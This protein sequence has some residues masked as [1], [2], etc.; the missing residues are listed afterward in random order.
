MT[1]ARYDEGPVSRFLVDD[2]LEDAPVAVMP[3]LSFARAL[4]TSFANALQTAHALTTTAVGAVEPRFSS[5]RPEGSFSAVVS[6]VRRSSAKSKP[7]SQFFSSWHVGADAEAKFG[8]RLLVVVTA[9]QSTGLGRAIA[10]EGQPGEV[11]VEFGE[12]GR[13]LMVVLEEARAQAIYG[14]APDDFGQLAI[15]DLNTN[16]TRP[17]L[18]QVA[19]DYL[20]SLVW[21]MR[22]SKSTF[23]K[24]ALSVVG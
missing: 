20:V 24:T 4:H 3:V 15:V 13:S 1:A 14:V 5:E 16:P 18:E 8:E 19:K 12:A 17:E 21:Q 10:Y 11:I 6:K 2:Q 7:L 23:R 9:M 22:L